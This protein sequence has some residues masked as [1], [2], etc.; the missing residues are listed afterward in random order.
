[1]PRA[2]GGQFLQRI[3]LERRGVHDVVRAGLGAVHREAVVMLAGDDDVLH[4]GVLGHLHPLLGIELHRI[5]LRGQ[6]LVL[7]DRDLGPVHDP[8]ADAGDLLALPF[9]G[10]NG[11]QPPV[12]EQAELGLAEPVHPRRLLG[13]LRLGTP[14]LTR[15]YSC[16]H[17]GGNGEQQGDGSEEGAASACWRHDNHEILLWMMV[18]LAVAPRA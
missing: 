3:A 8:L 15:L 18:L 14:A 12:D 17:R 7:L 5:E 16:W 11:I 9:P 10:G 6:L 4:A 1:M 2:G 13:G